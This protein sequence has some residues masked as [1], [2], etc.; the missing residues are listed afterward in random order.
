MR[1]VF[2]D[3]MFN[4]DRTGLK[5]HVF[6]VIVGT[7]SWYPYSE[8]SMNNDIVTSKFSNIVYIDQ[9]MIYRYSTIFNGFNTVYRIQLTVE[10]S[11][12]NKVAVPGLR[13]PAPL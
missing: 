3:K 2:D 1:G 6:C 13:T 5:I 10:I 12:M 8:I 11:Q 7:K 9:V 4:R